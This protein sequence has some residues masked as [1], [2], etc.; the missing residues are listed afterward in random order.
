M[1]R[2]S[3]SENLTFYTGSGYLS[4]PVAY[5][6]QQVH[7]HEWCAAC[8]A[9]QDAQADR[10]TLAVDEECLMDLYRCDCRGDTWRQPRCI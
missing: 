4:G 6:L 9:L 3:W 7:Q 1:H 5:L 10:V 2:R 8:N